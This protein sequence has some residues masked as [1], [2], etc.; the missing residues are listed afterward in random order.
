M[1]N[2]VSR[3]TPGKA[4]WSAEQAHIN[5]NVIFTTINTFGAQG[6]ESPG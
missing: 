3:A 2:G 5:P 6:Q 4:S 1:D